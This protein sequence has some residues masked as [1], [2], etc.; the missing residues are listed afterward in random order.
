MGHAH[1]WEKLCLQART[2][3]LLKDMDFEYMSDLR[4]KKLK[5]FFWGGGQRLKFYRYSKSG[6]VG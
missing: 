6:P 1:L 5:L 3:K 4:E 2:S